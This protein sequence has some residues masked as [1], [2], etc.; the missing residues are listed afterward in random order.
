[1]WPTCSAQN[2]YKFTWMP[3]APW[4]TP[5]S[6]SRTWSRS[7]GASKRWSASSNSWWT[8]RSTE[9][10][11]LPKRSHN[12]SPSRNSWPVTAMTWSPVAP[13]RRQLGR[14]RNFH[15]TE[16]SSRTTQSPCRRM[17]RSWSRRAR[18]VQQLRSSPWSKWTKSLTP[19]RST[20]WC[21]G[22]SSWVRV[23]RAPTTT[24]P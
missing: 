20:A 16:R 3:A 9:C 22:A 14:F 12:S 13:S 6:K 4:A 24:V 2:S 15:S 1:M 5:T 10:L 8:N 17:P 7:T 19:K 18:S 11:T 21:T 23:H